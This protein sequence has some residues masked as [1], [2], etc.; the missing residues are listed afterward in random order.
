M[1]ESLWIIDASAHE[2]LLFAGVGLLLGGIDDLLVDL[3]FIGHRLRDRLRHGDRPRLTVATLP[4]PLVAGGIAVFVA[5]WDEVAVIGGMLTTALSRYDH[6]DYRIY[7]GAYPNDRGT[8]DA[9]V[10]V[11][12]RDPRIRLVIGGRDGP[13]TKADCLNTL[14]RT[15]R[16]DDLREAASGRP[17]T[18]A[19]VIHDAEDVVHPQEL[20]VFDSLIERYDVIQLPVL[21][22]VHRGARLVSGHYADEFAESACVLP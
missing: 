16:R 2:M 6:A 12:E 11:A 17:P 15:L 14:W 10:A 20:R 1:S 9:I 22:L 13:T 19:I 3:L 18:K 5:A 7:V 4:P 21:P 8:I